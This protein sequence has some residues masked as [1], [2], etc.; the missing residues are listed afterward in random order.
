MSIFNEIGLAI[1]KGTEGIGAKAKV[2]RESS[3]L[4]SM[5]IEEEKKLA[6]YYQNVGQIYA[7]IHKTDYE[8]QFTELMELINEA[9]RNLVAY[10]RQAEE[11][12]QVRYCETCGAQIIG[13]SQFCSSCGSRV[14]MNITPFPNTFNDTMSKLQCQA[15]GAILDADSKFCERCGRP[16]KIAIPEP[17]PVFSEV[18]EEE[19]SNVPEMEQKPVN[20]EF[21]EEKI[22]EMPRSNKCPNCG[23]ELEEGSA[24]CGECGNRI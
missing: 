23:T 5:V 15:C 11:L 3:K 12:K 9:R 1:G 16:V 21:S 14:A 13:D 24:F 22:P 18:H 8:P 20:I 7:D 10:K 19:M 6:N 2:I 4:N 17:K